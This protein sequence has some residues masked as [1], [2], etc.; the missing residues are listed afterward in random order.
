VKRLPKIGLKRKLP[1]MLIN[2]ARSPSVVAASPP[3]SQ[4]VAAKQ[5][6]FVTDAPAGRKVI[7]KFRQPRRAVAAES[8]VALS[9]LLMADI[10][11]EPAHRCWIVFV[12][13]G[14]AA[15]KLSSVEEWIARP[16][17]PGATPT[18]VVQHNAEIIRWR[19]GQAVVQCTQERQEEILAALVEFAFYEG[20]LRALES[21]LEAHEAQ[22]QADVSIAYQIQR[23]DQKHWSRFKEAIEYFAHMRL[24]YAR[25]EPLLAKPSRT[26]SLRS[27]R[28]VAAL[29]REVDVE[30]RL[31]ALNDRLEA[32]EDLYEGANDRIADYRG[33]RIGTLLEIVIAMLL[34]LETI[35]ITLDIF[36]RHH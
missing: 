26:L 20:E 1:E 33:Y 32:L 23:R 21:G 19:P 4:R 9:D 12:P 2:S 11:A 7:R 17:E 34:L 29:F 6:C 28:V 22:A 10:R 31:E 18:I 24:T 8:A 15:E 3:S 13:K 35:I 27:Q 16:V 36:I 5:I 14:T 30:H 25:L